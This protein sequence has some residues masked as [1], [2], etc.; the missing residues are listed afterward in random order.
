LL[1]CLEL[2]VI[3]LAEEYVIIHKSAARALRSCTFKSDD[4]GQ[5]VL[6]LLLGWERSYRD[7]PHETDFLRD[8]YWT[9][10]ASY[11]GWPEVR[12]HLAVVLLPVYCRS[13]DRHFA[14]EMLD[15]LGER[16]SAYP[17]VVPTFV[18]AA[19]DHLTSTERD[20]YNDDTHTERGKIRDR[21]RALSP[22][23]LLAERERI[24]V[25]V[26][27]KAGK[28]PTEVIRTLEILS[29]LELHSEAAGLAE[30]ALGLVPAVKAHAYERDAYRLIAAAARAESLI[31]RGDHTAACEVLEEAASLP[32]PGE[33]VPSDGPPL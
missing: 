27:A 23:S 21:L 10:G 29:H 15:R 20:P 33:E 30:E 16:T 18:A 6:S 22:R 2:L 26:R 4:R 5:R 11:R 28:D 17:E 7:K 13:G 1:Q 31:S 14:E 3:Y 8:L 9:L 25:L 19:L 24:R 12:R 32:G